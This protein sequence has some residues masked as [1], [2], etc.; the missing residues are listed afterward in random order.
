MRFFPLKILLYSIILAFFL[1]GCS[2]VVKTL[3]GVKKPKVETETSLLAYLEKKELSTE[4]IF[5]VP[6]ESF[7]AVLSLTNNKIPDVLIFNKNGEYMPYGDEWACNANAFTFIQNLNATTTYK[8]TDLTILDSLLQELRNLDGTSL[9]LETI[10]LIK[11]GDFVAV[12]LWAKWTGKLN[13]TKVRE[14]EQQARENNN[15]K[16]VFVKLNVDLQPW[17]PM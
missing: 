12:A 7:K 17:W 5:S 11:D 16:I 14:W 13:K 8:T 1:T 6:M 4:H 15:S 2:L 9:S 3:Y 10:D